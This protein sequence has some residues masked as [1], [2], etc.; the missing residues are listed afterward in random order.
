MGSATATGQVA[1]RPKYQPK[2]SAIAA[3]TAQPAAASP[4]Q[5]R[6]SASA[7]TN[8]AWPTTASRKAQAWACQ[9]IVTTPSGDATKCRPM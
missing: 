8:T 3:D 1:N 7:A 4:P 5:A 9:A 2:Y 6:P